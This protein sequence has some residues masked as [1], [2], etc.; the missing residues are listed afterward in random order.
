MK[1]YS[2][3]I[4]FLLLFAT[5]TLRAHADQTPPPSTYEPKPFS[6]A[7]D[8]QILFS[9]GNLQFNAAQ[10]SH[11]CADGSIQQG[12]WRFAE[13]Q[14]DY[15]GDAE[16]GNVYQND[17]KSD[18]ALISDTYDGW[19]DLFSWGS[20]AARI[21]ISKAMSMSRSSGKQWKLQ[22]RSF[23]RLQAAGMERS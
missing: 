3:Y 19:I 7:P 11:S 2:R 5:C 1:P 10:G 17:V 4:L 8:K 20:R 22:E 18:N 12:T 23:S 16:N 21:K 6:V 14:W 9:S 15:V 13:H